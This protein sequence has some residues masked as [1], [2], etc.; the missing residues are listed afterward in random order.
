MLVPISVPGSVSPE[1]TF[2]AG[3]SPGVETDSLDEIPW[4]LDLTPWTE[5]VLCALEV[6]DVWLTRMPV[7]WQPLSQSNRRTSETLLVYS[8]AVSPVG[9]RSTPRILCLLVFWLSYPGSV[10]ASVLL[11]LLHCVPLLLPPLYIDVRISSI[12]LD[13]IYQLLALTLVRL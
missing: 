5:I 2:A 10:V 12:S 1:H 4:S 7:T 13:L 3:S 6:G 8:P 9:E 11:S